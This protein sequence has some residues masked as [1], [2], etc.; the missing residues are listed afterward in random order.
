MQRLDQALV[1]AETIS[2]GHAS[3]LSE[4]V[5]LST[6]HGA[7]VEVNDRVVLSKY[8]RYKMSTFRCELVL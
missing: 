2:E 3:F 6:L 1:Y 7:N 5:T 4:S 8:L